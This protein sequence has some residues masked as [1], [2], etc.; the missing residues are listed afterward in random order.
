MPMLAIH[1]GAIL[2]VLTFGLLFGWILWRWSRNSADPP[3]I[4][5]LKIILSLGLIGVS[6][7]C[8][9][10][11]HPILGVPV[12][13]AFAVV[14]G[15]LW[16]RNIGLMLANPLAS[17]YDGGTEAEPPKPFYAIAEAHRKQARYGQAIEAIEK[18]LELFPGDV[19]GLLML[20]EIRC[21][22]LQDW[23]GAE[24]AV[25]NILANEELPVATRAKALQALADWYLDLRHD[26]T[27]A[28]VILERITNLF[29]GTPE[30]N[31]ASRRM[32]HTGDGSWRREQHA[33]ALLRVV[34]SDQRLGLRLESEPPPPEPDP[35][36]EAEALRAQLSAHPLDTEGRERLAL[37]Y[38]DRMG[39]MDWALGEFDKLLSLPN[40]PPKSVAKWLH[41]LADIQVR[42]AGDEAGARAALLRV[43]ELFPG[44][45]LEANARSRL[46]R[47]KLEMRGRE[48]ATVVGERPRPED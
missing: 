2:S 31:E 22:N 44:T 35:E 38:A 1:P 6:V 18:Q 34:A 15:L 26:A 48:K 46:E 9:A 47:L 12:G 25:E 16:G 27:A 28:R 41:L 36:L 4:L 10:F 14:L 13:A 37:H 17:L 45:A 23:G 8:I 5:I 32:A 21:R 3:G 11:V 30:S 29:P 42:V 7:F 43:G 20:A 33:P 24:A 19:Q 39:R 40:Q